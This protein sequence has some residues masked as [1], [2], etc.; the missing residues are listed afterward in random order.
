MYPEYGTVGYMIGGKLCRACCTNDTQYAPSTA[1]L[2]RNRTRLSSQ[3]LYQSMALEV[4]PLGQ[5]PGRDEQGRRHQPE[6]AHREPGQGTRKDSPREATEI[7][8]A[9]HERKRVGGRKSPA[10][11]R[12]VG[13]HDDVRPRREHGCHSRRVVSREQDRPQEA[14]TEPDHD[15]THEQR[16]G[17]EALRHRLRTVVE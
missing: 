8:L 9:A 3:A 16:C 6:H 7:D 5:A 13:V 14:G 11:A 4:L 1:P 12:E 2:A 10:A 17:M 15:P